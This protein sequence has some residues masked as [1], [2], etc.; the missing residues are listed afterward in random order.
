MS[1]VDELRQHLRELRSTAALATPGPWTVTAGSK[2][3]PQR[4]MTEGSAKLVAEVYEGWAPTTADFIAAVTPDL[5]IALID[6]ALQRIEGHER[7]VPNEK[8]RGNHPYRHQEPW[9]CPVV[10]AEC[11]AWM[12]SSE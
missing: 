9:P 4:V 5:V 1:R 6:A 8:C 10:R 2:G 3:Y 12:G 11:S 7:D